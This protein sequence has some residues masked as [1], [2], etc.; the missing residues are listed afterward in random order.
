MTDKD[1][2]IWGFHGIKSEYVD[3]VL[4]H[5]FLPIDDPLLDDV[6]VDGYITASGNIGTDSKLFATGTSENIVANLNPT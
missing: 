5:G 6:D 4:R 2:E 1:Q 3:S